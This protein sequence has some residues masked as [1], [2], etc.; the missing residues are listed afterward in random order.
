[1]PARSLRRLLLG[2][3]LVLAHPALAEEPWAGWPMEEDPAGYG[4]TY[5]EAPGDEEAPL[6]RVLD[7]PAPGE[8]AEAALQDAL[9][10]LWLEMNEVE[11]R[12]E[13]DGR[14]VIWGDVDAEHGERR[15]AAAIEPAGEGGRVT[16]LVALPEDFERLG[17]PAALGAGEETRTAEG[18]AESPEAETPT[19][20]AGTEGEAVADAEPA[21]G[22]E[23]LDD[24]PRPLFAEVDGETV[25]PGWTKT[26]AGNY[27]GDPDRPEL[28]RFFGMDF[29]PG[30]VE[31][32][33]D[34]MIGAMASMDME[35]PEAEEPLEVPVFRELFDE[36]MWLGLGT[37]R[38]GGSDQVVAVEVIQPG[39]EDAGYKTRVVHA[40]PE[41]FGRWG[42][43][44]AVLEALGWLDEGMLDA[45]AHASIGAAGLEEQREIFARAAEVRLQGLLQE[46]IATMV[47]Q[48]MSTL[49]TMQQMNSNLQ[50]ETSCIA[51]GNCSIEYDG[52][53][54]AVP[55]FD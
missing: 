40:P 34:A 30:E 26:P 36:R 48:H 23:A 21:S 46:L 6:V 35:G 45:E 18:V 16:A 53:G 52:L 13:A 47:G 10:T 9:A 4:A 44:A 1:M 3:A 42:G 50:A 17:G 14:L 55:S 39:G 31:T 5:S 37:A 11:G 20:D 51:A 29:D 33:L 12:A 49:G 27:V 7:V 8:D 22:A 25:V 28:V 54:N 41:L 38:S 24:L 15:F 19:A 32:P 2:A 43:V